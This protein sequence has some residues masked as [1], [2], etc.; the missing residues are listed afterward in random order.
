VSI[1]SGAMAALSVFTSRQGG[2]FSVQQARLSGVTVGMQRHAVATGRFLKLHRGVLAIGGT[3]DTPLRR[4]WA[5]KL[6][7]GD[8]AIGSHRAAIWS[9][10]IGKD[11][12]L[13]EV[14]FTVPL[15]AHAS[16]DGLVIHRVP[17]RRRDYLFREG[18]PITTPV[19]TLL[20]AGAVLELGEVEDVFDR[21]IAKKL[22]TPPEAL[23]ELERAAKRGRSGC[24]ELRAVLLD[25]GLGSNRSPS[26]LEAKALRLFRRHGLPEPQVELVWG[27]HGQFRLD[28][29]WV[30]LGLVVEVDGWDCHSSHRAR[31]RDLSRRNQIVL[32]GLR[33]LIYTYGDIVHRG[34]TLVIPQIRQA[35]A[36]NGVR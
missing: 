36:D 19:R 2:A 13:D 28:F 10:K 27:D 3:P 29:I 20:D 35:L 24:G 6:A 22:V 1:P 11:D 9:W 7:L 21:A 5:G 32:G 31:Q 17:L 25:Q 23:A 4:V 18:L 8:R 14:D 33:P 30:E 12:T 16:R 34:D 15:K 26:F